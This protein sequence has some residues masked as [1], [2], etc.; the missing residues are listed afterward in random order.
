M[1]VQPCVTRINESIA[2]S[3]KME[4]KIFFPPEMALGQ[5]LIID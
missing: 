5:G 4:K 2:I 3:R 1:P